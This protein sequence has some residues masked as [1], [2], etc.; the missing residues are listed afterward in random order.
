MARMRLV[1]SDEIYDHKAAYSYPDLVAL[2]LE[3][4]FRPNLIQA[5]YFEWGMNC[6]A[7]AVKES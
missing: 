3:A 2:L 1:S 7:V 6:W 4:G 5:G